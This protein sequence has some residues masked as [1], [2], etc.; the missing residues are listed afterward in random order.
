[1]ARYLFQQG[2]SHPASSVIW[3]G[4]EKELPSSQDIGVHCD[5][6]INVCNV[7]H[8]IYPLVTLRRLPPP[9]DQS[10]HFAIFL[11]RLFQIP[12][13]YSHEYLAFWIWLI[14]L[15]M[16]TSDL[17]HFLPAGNTITFSFT[18]DK[19]SP[20]CVCFSGHLPMGI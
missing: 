16:I 15:N 13:G 18:T 11:F 17:I 10:L 14:F 20:H 3:E 9:S 2:R 5:I 6:S 8:D 4:R 12:H 7:L 19:C 1:M